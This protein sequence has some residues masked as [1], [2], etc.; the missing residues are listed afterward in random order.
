[1]R[2]TARQHGDAALKQTLP[3]GSFVFSKL[4]TAGAAAAKKL[5]E[6]TTVI[7]ILAN[8]SVAT[9]VKQDL[10]GALACIMNALQQ[11]LAF[12]LW[13]NKPSHL[14]PYKYLS[15]LTT[16]RTNSTSH[17][18]LAICI[19]IFGDVSSFVLHGLL[20]ATQV[21]ESPMSEAFYLPW[22]KH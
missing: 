2:R 9:V 20:Y 15:F 11:S 10:L 19:S 4:P 1:M 8:T 3:V 16:Q 7:R 13:L 22:Q 17:S 6:V 12:F 5:F 14:Q 18:T 21:I